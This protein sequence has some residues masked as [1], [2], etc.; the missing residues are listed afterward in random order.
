M[1][2]TWLAVVLLALT[3]SA[4]E[5]AWPWGEP[6]GPSADASAAPVDDAAVAAAA[7]DSAATPPAAAADSWA[8]E[9]GEQDL[10]LI[11]DEFGGPG[12]PGAGP[13]DSASAASAPN[14]PQGAGPGPAPASVDVGAYEELLRENIDLRREISQF[15]Q[16]AQ[17]AA[18]DKRRLESEVRELERQVGES[19]A[20]IQK[21]RQG[22]EPAPAAVAPADAGA[23]AGAGAELEQLRSERDALA[24]QLASLQA[25]AV[26][27]VDPAAPAQGSD[28][29]RRLEAENA[30]LKSRVEQAES[31]RQ[32][33]EA[34]MATLQTERDEGLSGR[35]DARARETA[36]EVELRDARAQQEKLQRAIDKLLERVPEMETGLA[37][38]RDTVEM[39]D[40][41]L[42]SRGRELEMLRLEMDKR[43]QRLI[44][45]ERMTAL[46]EKSR[47]EVKA[48][49]KKEERDLHYNMASVYAKEGR[50]REAEQ[51]YLKA[52]R[53][54]PTDA[55]SHY[56]LGILYDEVFSEKSKAAMHYRAYL[57][58]APN[59]PDS[60]EVKSWLLQ[61]DLR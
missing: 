57:K 13:S 36:M 15:E 47:A 31:A 34:A 3:S 26:A 20:L 8:M 32:Q 60:D 39:K 30:E 27:A 5:P 1:T 16:V 45:A 48:F 24:A 59:A 42:M 19:V 38:M 50:H 4:Q 53:A 17:E 12:G 25:Q 56:N 21:M 18:S 22:G 44:K 37:E 6:A 61:L 9:G 2:A 58:L 33:A 29:F 28:L 7:A 23:A 49:S 11:E 10:S 35:E 52:L 54:D 55:G 51:E 43:E 14:G 40:R 46:M 41:E